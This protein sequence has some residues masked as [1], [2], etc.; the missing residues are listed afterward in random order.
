MD[1]TYTVPHDAST[2]DSLSPT[3]VR[4]P[5]IRPVSWVV[6]VSKKNRCLPANGQV[7]TAS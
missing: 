6:A 4:N 1:D 7:Y 3:R 2:R 5:F